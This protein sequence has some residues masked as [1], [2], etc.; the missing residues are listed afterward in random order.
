MIVRSGVRGRN[1]TDRGRTRP[2]YRPTPTCEH[3]WPLELAD[4]VSRLVPGSDP[5]RFYRKDILVRVHC[6]H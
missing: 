5:A 2:E 3:G 1:K 6:S 4:R